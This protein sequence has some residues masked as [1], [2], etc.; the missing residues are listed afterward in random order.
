MNNEVLFTS[1]L[2]DF[3][4]DDIDSAAYALGCSIDDLVTDGVYLYDQ[5]DLLAAS[6]YVRAYCDTY[7]KIN[8]KDF[9][10]SQIV[11]A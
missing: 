4:N 11:I 2:K 3:S 7:N 6:D 9:S 1:D 8:L 5:H 10:A